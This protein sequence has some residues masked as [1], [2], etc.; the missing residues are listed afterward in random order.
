MTRKK[1][2]VTSEK[3]TLNYHDLLSIVRNGI[4]VAVAS[5][6]GYFLTQMD[7]INNIVSSLVGDS[8]GGVLVT[9]WIVFLITKTLDRLSRGVEE[10][11]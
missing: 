5:S 2:G 3:W 11:K 6:A 10:Q 7:T 9:G 4:M 1:T 8:D